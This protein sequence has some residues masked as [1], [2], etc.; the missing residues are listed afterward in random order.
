MPRH[1]LH[2][3]NHEP[4]FLLTGSLFC[5]LHCLAVPVPNAAALRSA[6]VLTLWL[7]FLFLSCVPPICY[8]RFLDAQSFAAS[9]TPN[10]CHPVSQSP[11]GLGG[12]VPAKSLGVGCALCYLCGCRWLRRFRRLALLGCWL[13]T[14]N[15][16]CI[17]VCYAV[18]TCLARAT[19]GFL[20][21]FT[22]V[23]RSTSPSR[24]PM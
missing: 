7:W 19:M 3:T 18:P 8:L 4:V 13:P 21:V 2:R 16:S 5:L 1:T 20:T 24:A 11:T 23:T 17:S 12:C 10:C 6:A 22:T 15:H 14:F 9:A